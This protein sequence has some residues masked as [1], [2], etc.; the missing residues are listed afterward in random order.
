[1]RIEVEER[2]AGLV[3]RH[4]LARS[5][6]TPL[7]V[8]RSLAAIHSSDPITP[9]LSMWARLSGF[10]TSDLDHALF[11]ARSL[12]R[13]HAMRRTLFVVPGADAG[14]FQAGAAR[15]IADRE[16]GRVIG[17]L[18]SE[19]DESAAAA[20][21]DELSESVLAELVDGEQRTVELSDAIPGLRRRL[22][23]SSGKWTGTAPLSSRLLYL[24]AM[25]GLVVRTRPAGSWRSSQYRW[26]AADRWFPSP[27]EPIEPAE[28]RA[29]LLG[30]YLEAYGP[31]TFTDIKWWTG[32]TVGE[33]R[34]ALERADV[35]QVRLDGADGWVGPGYASS[36]PVSGVVSLLPSLDSTSMGWKDRDWYLPPELVAELF[37]RH[38]NAGPTVWADGSIIGGWTHAPD[39]MVRHRL[40][41]PTDS[42]TA[43]RAEFECRRLATWLGESRAIPRFR[44]PLEREL[45]G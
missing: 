9:H 37:D 10:E 4:H 19:M 41:V 20:L 18:G 7:E 40:L 5:G 35:R 1:M 32:W 28:G 42:E 3:A 36:Q 13:L 38:G 14:I 22:A 30:R 34:A 15:T 21:L 24:M 2:R 16:R 43:D 17:W 25:D 31:A 12:W 44:T 26:A 11:E 45:A 23:V 8:V 39:G 33:T 27:P 29:R 6:D